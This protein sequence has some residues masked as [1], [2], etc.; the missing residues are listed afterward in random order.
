MASSGRSPPFGSTESPHSST[1]HDHTPMANSNLP[2]H[3]SSSMAGSQS[4]LYVTGPITL[5]PYLTPSANLNPRS[6]V[7][8][9]R[10]KVRCDKHM[11]C[12]NCRK[13]GIQCAFP[14]PGRAPRR[15][16]PK[17]PNAPPKQTSEREMELLKRLRKLESIVEDLS[18]QIEFDT[19]KQGP[20]SE[21]SEA[22][23]DPVHE[24]DRRKTPASPPVDHTSPNNA[25][26]GHSLL[27]RTG[28][29]G[30]I[31]SPSNAKTHGGDVNKDFGKL[32]LNESGKVRYVSNAFWTKISEEVCIYI[33]NKRRN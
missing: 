20:N 23:G 22:N 2:A 4:Q 17:D 32:V 10:R 1:P 33:Y 5:E 18:G 16:R 19:Y 26:A 8:C 21:S 31:T 12:G 14:A 6:C 30:S 7:T 29:G 24:I 13:A 11:P 3:L 15:P 27:R 25:P 28:T 9:R